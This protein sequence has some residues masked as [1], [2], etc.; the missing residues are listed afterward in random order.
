MEGE[1]HHKKKLGHSETLALK[2]FLTGKLIPPGHGAISHL[3]TKGRQ[4]VLNVDLMTKV[5]QEERLYSS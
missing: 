1:N 5:L 4:I 2:Y 3:T